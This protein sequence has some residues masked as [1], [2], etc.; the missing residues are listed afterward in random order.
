MSELVYLRPQKKPTISALIKEKVRSIQ[1]FHDTHK[2]FVFSWYK[3]K[4]AKKNQDIRDNSL[5][6]AYPFISEGKGF[7]SS[8]A[9]LEIRRASLLQTVNWGKLAVLR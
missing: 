5:R 7:T 1:R 4:K 9:P 3:T 2:V 8:L 6:T